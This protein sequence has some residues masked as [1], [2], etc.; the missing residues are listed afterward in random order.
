MELFT[1]VNKRIQSELSG[2]D[3]QLVQKKQELLDYQAKAE[4]YRRSL[5]CCSKK[6]ACLSRWSP[7]APS[8]S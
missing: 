6:S 3:E 2:L 1:S 7:R 5:G 4:Q 8:Q